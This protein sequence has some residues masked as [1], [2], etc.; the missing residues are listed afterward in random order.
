MTQ[1]IEYF[2][3]TH[4]AY[5]YLGTGR[6]RQICNQ[7]NR[8]VRHV[9]FDLRAALDASGHAVT[10]S[11]TSARR[12]YFFGREILRWSEFRNAPV[13]GIRPTWHDND[14]AL[15]STMVIAAEQTGRDVAALTDA[16]LRAHWKDD[17][18][19]ADAPTLIRLAD[20][21]EMDGKALLEKAVA[22][23]IQKIYASNTREAIERN[24]FGSP[25]YFVDGDMFYGQ[26]RLELVDRAI[27]TPFQ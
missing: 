16:I 9:P 20:A 14:L 12:D 23:A 17:A 10:G 2:Y 13:M 1:P 19:I 15:S 4:S 27:Q 6:L 25:T 24:V 8:A 26:D 22:P 7:H 18:D 11:L 3:S 5:A 21:L